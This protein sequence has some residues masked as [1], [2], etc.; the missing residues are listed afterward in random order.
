MEPGCL[1]FWNDARGNEV[2]AVPMLLRC[3][4]RQTD[5]G[6]YRVGALVAIVTEIHPIW[7]LV[8]PMTEPTRITVGQAILMSIKIDR[9]VPERDMLFF[10]KKEVMS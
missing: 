10:D 5:P 4:A 2:N 8:I 1:R 6:G 3:H 7:K 9:E